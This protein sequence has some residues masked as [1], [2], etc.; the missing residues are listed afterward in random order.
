MLN[1]IAQHQ[2]PLSAGLNWF[3]ALTDEEQRAAMS[4]LHLYVHQ[5]HPTPGMVLAAIDAAPVRRGATPLALLRAFPF[6]V[7]LPKIIILR[8]DE[9][10]N[11]FAALLTLFRIADTHR[12][13]TCCQH[14]CSHDWHHLPPLP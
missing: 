11:A 14:G 5:S 13:H 10:R 7:A 1:R 4:E 12:R 2:L 3:E 9:R 8:A 6:H